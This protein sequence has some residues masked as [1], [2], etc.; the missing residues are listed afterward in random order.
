MDDQTQCAEH[1]YLKKDVSELEERVKKSAPLWS[2][3]LLIG[4]M[5]S[6]ATYSFLEIGKVRSELH[7]R[8]TQS[9]EM[10]VS[11]LGAIGNTLSEVKARQEII[12]QHVNSDR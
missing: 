7:A 2:L 11:R 3:I 6:T 12:L 8:I 9:N 1:C 4:I 10:V 5:I